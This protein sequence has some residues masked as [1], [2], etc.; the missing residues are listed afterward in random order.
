[1]NCLAKLAFSRKEV[2]KQIKRN[3]GAPADQSTV[4]RINE[5]LPLLYHEG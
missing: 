3:C 1:M 5:K 4:H 2:R